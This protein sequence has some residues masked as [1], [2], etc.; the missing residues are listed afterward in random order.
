MAALLRELL[1]EHE[2]MLDLS[3]GIVGEEREALKLK[4]PRPDFIT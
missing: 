4:V 2:N 3:N 1:G